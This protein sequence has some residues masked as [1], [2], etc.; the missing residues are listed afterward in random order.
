MKILGPSLV[1]L[2][3]ARAWAT[4]KG[5]HQ[6]FVSVA[7]HYWDKCPRYGIPAELAYAQAAHETNWGKF[8]GIVPSTF[9]NWCGLKTKQGG[10]NT[11]A[12]AHQKFDDDA[13]GVLAHIQHLA[14]YAGAQRVVEGDALVDPRWSVVTKFTD[15]VEG[16]G[17]AWAPS[18][19][20]GNM[21]AS[22]TNDL[23]AFAQSG[24]GSVPLQPPV[25]WT[26]PTIIRRVLPWESSN[27]PGVKL[28]GGSWDYITVHNTG[29]QSPTANAEHHAAW[30]ESLA[31][32]GADEPSWHYT[33]D[34]KTIIQHL[35]DDW[36]AYHAS[37]AG[38][39]G[40]FDS[41]GLEL[42]E[43]GNQEFV[44]WNA[45]WLIA[46]KLKAR[47][48]DTEVMRQH[49]DWARDKKNCPRLLRANGGAGWKKLY[50]IVGYFQ[51]QAPQ[52]TSQYFDETG[53]TVG[54]GFLQ[55]WKSQGGLA[56][57]GYPITEEFVEKGHTVQ[58]FERARFEHH[59]NTNPTLWDVMLG[60]VGAELIGYDG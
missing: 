35:E 20:Y 60:R 53:F 25:G 24:G 27:T 2:E 40:N 17:G 1:T 14:R 52:P 22:L 13:T 18:A 44:I 6:R 57:F 59:P 8:T 55:F 16:L 36:A 10:S 45:G 58:Y 30:L 7:W 41:L 42:C 15:E 21:I 9:H 47:D 34:E 46:E 49:Y 11:S 3:Q 50:E 31:A 54:G 19:T 48:K 33:V 29:N 38:G 12:T 32:S 39:D 37:D 51:R 23:R 56:I 28:N 5:A 4:A 43:I 26:P